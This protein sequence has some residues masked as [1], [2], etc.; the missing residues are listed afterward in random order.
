MLD[1]GKNY[2]HSYTAIESQNDGNFIK[3]AVDSLLRQTL[4]PDEIIIVDDGSNQATLEI[5]SQ[6][7]NPRV[8]IVYQENQGVSVARNNGIIQSQF[9]YICVLDADDYLEAT[10]L[11]KAK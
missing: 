6:F 9:Q 1:Y 7:N 10:F 4:M 11:E 3:S 2:F 8:N 5:L